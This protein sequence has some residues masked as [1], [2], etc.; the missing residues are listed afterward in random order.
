MKSAIS[1]PI[2]LLEEEEIEKVIVEIN[3][4]DFCLG[5][6]HLHCRGQIGDQFCIFS[7]KGQCYKLQIMSDNPNKNKISRVQFFKFKNN[8]IVF[9]FKF[10]HDLFG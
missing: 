1:G 5:L 8:I 9:F 6:G 3:V 7:S 2:A 10:L 4:I